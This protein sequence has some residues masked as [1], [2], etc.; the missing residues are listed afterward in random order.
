MARR[1][2][3]R[4]KL[5]HAEL[6]AKLKDDDVRSV[7]HGLAEEVKAHVEA[8]GIKVGDR[9]GG[10]AEYPLPV[11]INSQTTDRA[12]EVV[13]I[14]H[15]AGIAVQAKHGVLTKAASAVGLEVKSKN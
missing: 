9:D 5:N 15:A 7:V 13:T 12:R 1:G 14:P 3:L 6:E 4:V 8:Q 2:G 10:P 11:T